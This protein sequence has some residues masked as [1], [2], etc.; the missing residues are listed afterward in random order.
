MVSKT[1]PSFNSLAQHMS[2]VS[3]LSGS[4]CQTGLDFSLHHPLPNSEIH[5]SFTLSYL[6]E[7]IFL[8]ITWSRTIWSLDNQ[9]STHTHGD[10][11]SGKDPGRSSC[12]SGKTPG[13]AGADLPHWQEAHT[14]T[15]SLSG[16]GPHPLL[17]QAFFPA[18]LQ[19]HP[20]HFLCSL[21][22]N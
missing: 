9:T 3:C 12:S 6:C 16:G 5:L 4:L 15:G 19:P 14:L 13:I 7:M 20:H 1:L 17:N 22:V 11:S 21:C 18:Y 10:Q 2:P 8:S